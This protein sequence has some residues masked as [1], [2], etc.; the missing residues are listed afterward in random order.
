M[1]LLPGGTNPAS[2]SSSFTNLLAA[3][4]IALD[5]TNKYGKGLGNSQKANFAPR[6]GFAYQVSP[7]LVARGGFGMFYNGFENRGYSPNLG[8]SYPFQFDFNYTPPNDGIPHTYPSSCATAGPGGTATFE[9]GFSCIPLDPTKVLANGLQ[10]RG[11]QFNYQ[12]PYT[13]SGNFTLQYQLT[14]TLSVQA[15]YVTS[16]AR[17]LETFPNS[18]NPTA[19]LPTGTQLTNTAGNN[20]GVGSGAWPSA[21]GGI[22]FPDFGNGG[23]YAVTNGNSYYNGLQ[24]KVEKRFGAGLNFLAT[25]TWSQTRT[26]AGDLLNGGSNA[27]FRAPD[28][29]G[30]GIHYDYGLGGFDIRNVFHLSGGYELPFGKGKHFLGDSGVASKVFGGWSINTSVVLQGGQPITLSCPSNTSSGSGCY[31]LI[32]PGQSLDRGV[33]IDS[34]G[35]VSF[36]GNR[37]AFSQPATCAA[38]PCPVSTLGGPPDQIAG[39]TFKRMDFSAFK[40]IPLNERFRLEFRAEFFNLFNHPNFNAPNF[41]GNGVVAVSNSGNFTSSNFGEIGSTRDA[42][43]DPRQIQFALKLYF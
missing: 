19:I 1:Y 32:V 2:L 17:H 10:L 24:T 16:L 20:G 33:H 29:P 6:V 22:P 12:T 14:P 5:I 9:S 13:M 28:V 23:S 26:D 25:Y 30:L 31:D 39:P 43:Y 37:A 21:Q 8:E 27:S 42:P 18:N 15:G 38:L 7:K 3:D 35:K 41:G 4:G 40:Q 11:I 34:N 36:F